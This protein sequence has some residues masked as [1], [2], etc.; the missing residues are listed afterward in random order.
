[1]SS[2]YLNLGYIIRAGM[3]GVVKHTLIIKEQILGV[4]ERERE[5]VC[6]CLGEMYGS[7]CEIEAE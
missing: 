5:C 7:E 1:M 2:F 6:V 4:L 3:S